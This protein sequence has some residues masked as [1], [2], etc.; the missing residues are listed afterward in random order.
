MMKKIIK[1]CLI[2]SLSIILGGIIFI[3][4]IN[5]G[6]FMSDR[7]QDMLDKLQRASKTKE[8][9]PVSDVMESPWSHVCWLD[10][11]MT[12]SLWLDEFLNTKEKS[13]I[14]PADAIILPEHWGLVFYDEKTRRAQIYMIA[15]H[16]LASKISS[17][18]PCITRGN[19]FFIKEHQPQNYP[20]ML[21]LSEGTH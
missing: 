9:F 19:A 2:V 3:K 4:Y 17:S 21:V 18:H 7:D 10:E 11:N 1:G 14:I 16:K 20:D 5:G 15:Q 13:I 12:P 8:Y 6:A